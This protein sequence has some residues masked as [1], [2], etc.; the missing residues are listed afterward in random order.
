M[1]V[2]DEI[3]DRLMDW[4]RQTFNTGRDDLM[5]FEYEVQHQGLGEL[6]QEMMAEAWLEGGVA[7]LNWIDG[8]QLEDDPKNPYRTVTENENQTD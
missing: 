2:E 8:H 4:A 6:V 5:N 1:A 7:V 3:Y